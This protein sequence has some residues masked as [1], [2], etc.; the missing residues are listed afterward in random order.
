M[1]VMCK[2]KSCKIRKTSPAGIYLLN[3]N[4]KTDENVGN[5]FKVSNKDTRPTLLT[6]FW[7]LYC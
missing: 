3:V 5:L 6:S 4:N 1:K 7:C 2:G